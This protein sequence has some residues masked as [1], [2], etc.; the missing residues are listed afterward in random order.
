MFR[1][2]MK[3]QQKSN[4][5]RGMILKKYTGLNISYESKKI[6][7]SW[8]TLLTHNDVVSIFMEKF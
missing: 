5:L 8:T 6:I 2:D 4:I 3:V 7:K 1:K